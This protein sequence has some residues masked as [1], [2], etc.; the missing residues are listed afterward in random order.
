MPRKPDEHAQGWSKHAQRVLTGAG[1]QRGGARARI[2][3]LLARETCA[4]SA[5]E[6]EDALCAEGKSI[7]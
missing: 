5:V 6:I 4:L 1:H 2:I 3:E 7:G